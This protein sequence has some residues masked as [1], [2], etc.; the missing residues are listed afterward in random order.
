LNPLSAFPATYRL[1]LPGPVAVPESVRHACAAP[2]LNHRGPEFRARMGALQERLKPLIGTDRNVLV[3]ASSGTGMMEASLANIGAPGESLLVCVAGQFGQRYA[4]IGRALG[5]IVD[6][7]EFE[8]A[9]AIDPERVAAKLKE[10]TYRAVVVVH[11]ESSTG[12]TEDLEAISSVVRETDALLVVDSVSGLG[13]ML[14][15]QDAWGIDILVSASQKAL[16]C[17]PG[18]GLASL[19]LKARAMVE[20]EDRFPRFYWDFRKALKSIDD[21]ETP[22]TTPV[23]NVMGLLQAFELMHEEGLEQVIARHA[24]L[25]ETFRQGCTAL[26]FRIYG[27]PGHLSNTVVALE[28][29]AGIN[30]TDIV[31]HMREQYG[32][33]IAG[34]RN[35]L[36]GRVIRLGT[37]GDFTIAD[38]EMDLSL[39]QKTLAHL[40]AGAADSAALASA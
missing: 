23:S 24:R 16:M 11:N 31:K 15:K 26:G 10:K 30:G 28:V 17:P 35:K 29:P 7:L 14:V 8:W 27:A 36:Q 6:E 5:F 38:V 37:M 1:R 13:G 39:L 2:V 33:I 20:R 18:V 19:S 25:A 40:G 34:S 12:T 3:F 9:E 32:T 21:N 22:F 4:S